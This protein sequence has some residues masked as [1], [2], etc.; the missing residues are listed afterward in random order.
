MVHLMGRTRFEL[1]TFGFLPAF[2]GKSP[3]LYQAELPAR[4][5][6]FPAGARMLWAGRG[7]TPRPGFEPGS[8]P[9]CALRQTGTPDRAA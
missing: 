8:Q 3:L 6:G 9:C 2:A 4:E 7:L 1:A 5:S